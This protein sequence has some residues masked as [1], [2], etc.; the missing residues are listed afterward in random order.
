MTDRQASA[1]STEGQSKKPRGVHMPR[2][3]KRARVA[4][5]PV[6]TANCPVEG[7]CERRLMLAVLEDA[8]NVY[9]TYAAGAQLGWD[10]YW[11]ASPDHRGA[12]TFEAICDA[13]DLNAEAVR[14]ALKHFRETVPRDKRAAEF[15]RRRNAP[16]VFSDSAYDGPI[17]AGSEREHCVGDQ[18]V[19]TRNWRP[20]L[21]DSPA[22]QERRA[23]LFR[24]F[25][26]VREEAYKRGLKYLTPHQVQFEFGIAEFAHDDR[27]VQ[28]VLSEGERL[29]YFG[30]VMD[31]TGKRRVRKRPML[32]T[33]SDEPLPAAV[34]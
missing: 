8:I 10:E 25:D 29:G 32:P 6:G 7:R 18:R 11:F 1:P 22:E 21:V 19:A 14:Q 3:S 26:R 34:A 9:C 15:K 27:L 20:L 23:E 28:A 4:E 12:F 2:G 5:M 33:A 30:P 24:L 13:L 31:I 16:P 17:E